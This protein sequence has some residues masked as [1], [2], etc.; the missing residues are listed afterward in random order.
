MPPKSVA[1]NGGI[2]FSAKNS[3]AFLAV[4]MTFSKY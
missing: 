2:A 1:T 4:A 3:C